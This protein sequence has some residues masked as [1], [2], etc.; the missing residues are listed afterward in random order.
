VG[1]EVALRRSH[2]VDPPCHKPSQAHEGMGDE[3]G[4]VVVVWGCGVFFSPVL[5][6]HVPSSGP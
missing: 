3:C 5:E 2:L 1:G 4:G 6:K